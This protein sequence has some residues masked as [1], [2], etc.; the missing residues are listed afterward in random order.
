MFSS[1]NIAIAFSHEYDVQRKN[2]ENAIRCKIAYSIPKNENGHQPHINFT[3]S[4]C[5]H[6]INPTIN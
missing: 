1:Q 5:A 2:F 3:K 6:N 4:N